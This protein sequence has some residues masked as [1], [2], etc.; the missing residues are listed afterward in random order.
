MIALK[1]IS[2]GH[3]FT[4]CFVSGQGDSAPGARIPGC[5]ASCVVDCAVGAV[6]PWSL[7]LIQKTNGIH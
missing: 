7:E 2:P 3:L 1:I 6:A 5:D 4:A